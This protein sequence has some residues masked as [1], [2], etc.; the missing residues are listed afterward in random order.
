MSDDEWT[1]EPDRIPVTGRPELQLYMGGTAP[2]D[3][4][5]TGVLYNWGPL[6]DDWAGP[7][8]GPGDFDSVIT[9]YSAAAPVNWG[10]LEQ[11]YGF[12]DGPL[13]QETLEIVHRLADWGVAELEAGR[14][15]LVRCQQGWNRSG[16][17]TALIMIRLG[18]TGEDAITTIREARSEWCL[19]NPDFEEYLRSAV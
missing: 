13:Y 1:W 19:C 7:R 8:V 6:D 2:E 14:R 3:D 5:L 15:L 4:M 10:V 16:L 9:L 11:R 12:M 18:M 17:V